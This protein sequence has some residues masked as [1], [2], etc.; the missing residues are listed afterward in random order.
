MKITHIP[1]IDCYFSSLEDKD[2]RAST[3]HFEYEIILVTEGRTQIQINHHSYTAVAPSLIFISRLEQHSLIPD[4]STV[5]KRYVASVGSEL[6]MSYI[7]DVELASIFILRPKNFNHVL[8]LPD[9]LYAELL[10]LFSRLEKETSE[11]H[12]FY[13]TQSISIVISLLIEL[14]R[15]QPDFFPSRSSNNLSELVMDTQ[16][17]VSQNFSEKITLQD[18]ADKYYI[19]RRTLS[20]AFKEAVGV[21]F[22]DYLILYRMT[23]AKKMLITTDLSV[24]DV[25]Q[26]IG[27]SNVNN[28]VKI[29]KSKENTT[30][31]QFRKQFA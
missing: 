29:F 4:S 2:I 11:K 24:T 20:V 6:I 16:R 31:L 13:I 30:P 14:Y 8:A 27:Y 10:S 21:T 19:N 26:L 9:D 17:Y 15:W 22:K 23:E 12:P 7:K 5:Y 18:I 3:A 1:S 28:F 25:S